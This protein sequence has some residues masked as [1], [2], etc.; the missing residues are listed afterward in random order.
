[1]GKKRL[2]TTASTEVTRIANDEDTG[3]A[4]GPGPDGNKFDVHMQDEVDGVAASEKIVRCLKG[5]G[6]CLC[7]ANAPHELL[8]QAYDE[9]EALWKGN[10]FGPPMQVYDTD[11]QFE[12]QLWSSLLYQDEAKVLWIA[13]EAG[14]SRRKMDALKLL[15]Q[16]MQDFAV[17]L[18]DIMQQELR[19]GFTHSWNAML[20]CYTGSKSYC[21]HID[22]P[23]KSGGE[24]AL[25]D[26]G[27]RLTLCYYINPHWD[28]DS[29]VNGGGL[30]VFL[31]DPRKAPPAASAARKAPKLR[32]APHADTLALFLS[33]RMAHQVVETSGKDRWYCL[34]MWCFDQVTMSN[35]VPQVSTRQRQMQ[36]GS[37]DEYE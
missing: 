33:E 22:N 28:P 30:D 11:S 1:M 12:A 27:L 19:V 18:G 9:A 26:N 16:N 13:D 23:H 25:P 36:A 8:S 31:T 35:F 21:L 2:Q 24:T 10:E 15:S 29:G 4:Q 3:F 32:I 14:S 17:G 6:V 7:E 37:D 34:T 5:R 20:S